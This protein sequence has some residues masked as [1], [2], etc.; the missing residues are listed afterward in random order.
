LATKEH[1]RSQK[2]QRINLLYA[3]FGVPLRQMPFFGRLGDIGLKAASRKPGR[4]GHKR[5]QRSQKKQRIS[6]LYAFFSVPLRQMPFFGRVWPGR[7][8]FAHS[9]GLLIFIF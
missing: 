5:A 4:I 7:V 9:P 2:K 6:L 3:F 1:E 8:N